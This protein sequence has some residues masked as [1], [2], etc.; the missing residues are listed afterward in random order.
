MAEMIRR[1]KEVMERA[2]TWPEEAQEE[3]A[4]IALQ[5]EGELS[6][7][8]YHATPDELEPI[9]EA[10]EQVAGGDIATDEDVEAA[11]RT[12]RRA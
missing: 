12:F 3:L 10:L 7:G 11:F 1:L 4:D 9:D 2:Q 8:D 5:I 6:G